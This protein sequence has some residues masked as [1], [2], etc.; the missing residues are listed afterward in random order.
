MRWQKQGPLIS[1]DK[2]EMICGS[3]PSAYEAFLHADQGQLLPTVDRRG[4]LGLC[5]MLQNSEFK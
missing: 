1:C 3:Q 5:A 2:E 4:R